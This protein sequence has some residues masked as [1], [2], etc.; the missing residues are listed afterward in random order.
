L[1]RCR[2]QHRLGYVA[3]L[4]AMLGGIFVVFLLVQDLRDAM[5]AGVI[6]LAIGLVAMQW[7]QRRYADR[8]R[9]AVMPA[10]CGAVG[11]ISHD[12][13]TAPDLDLDRL[14]KVGLVPRHDR[15]RI[16]DAFCGRHRDTG[17]TM[18][19]VRLRR[20]GGGR[21]RSSRMV[22]RGLVFAIEVPRPVPGLILI[23]R[24]GGLIGNGLSGWMKGFEGM[25]RVALPDEA[26]EAS[27]EIYADRPEVA[28]A[29]VTPAL[30]ANLVAL[31]AAQGGAPF[32]AAFADGRFFVAMRKRGDR[33]RV[34]SL[35]RSTDQL[36]SEA[37]CLLGE[38]Q[39]V[40]RLIDHLHGD[41][42]RL[43]PAVKP[44]AEDRDEA[45]GPVVRG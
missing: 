10:V 17:F 34:G 2:R 28:R 24:D 14:A 22:F 44:A 31:A 18:A 4:A 5:F 8:V 11:D 25:Q 20:R 40:H 16:D 45:P 26:F 13:G 15:Q 35:F 12:V 3:A 32:Q 6:V 19:E 39:I 9:R 36:E 41:R 43:E 33:F 38:V 21:R 37:A 42:P 7:A 30:C 1:E 29:T 27:F 23:A